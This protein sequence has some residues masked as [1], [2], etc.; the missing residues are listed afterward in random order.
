MKNTKL[1]LVIVLSLFFL[2]GAWGQV[3]QWEFYNNI[4]KS[5]KIELQFNNIDLEHGGKR[6]G[7][8]MS[9][10]INSDYTVYLSC[11]NANKMNLD[12]QGG[13][14]IELYI[15][16]SGILCW[17]SEKM[18]LQLNITERTPGGHYKYQTSYDKWYLGRVVGTQCDEY[19]YDFPY[20]DNSYSYTF[21]LEYGKDDKG[22]FIKFLG[23][24]IV[25][26]TRGNERILYDYGVQNQERTNAFEYL[27]KIKL[28]NKPIRFI[29]ETKNASEL[30]ADNSDMYG[31]WQWNDDRSVIYLASTTKD[32][33]LCIW[34]NEGNLSWGFIMD[35]LATG[36]RTETS[37]GAEL[38]YLMLSF[39][40][41]PEQSFSFGKIEDSNQNVFLH[42]QYDRFKGTIKQDASIL[43]QIKDKGT[44]VLSY[45]QSGSSKTAMFQ[46]EGLE[47][48]Y[49][50]ITQ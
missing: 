6:C 30:N 27:T 5:R 22:S 41:S 21:V 36:Y 17:Q 50:A 11:S 2:N 39:D 10:V 34:N 20:T 12:P 43:S 38:A 35:K 45:K 42:V 28:T 13:S 7:E 29:S 25:I 32:V 33:F 15:F 48:I 40:G 37:S 18:V 46:L 9:F 49:N 19:R 44:L 26:A 16:G 1:L 8:K 3:S 4:P 24:D 47:A 31:K 14:S 23:D